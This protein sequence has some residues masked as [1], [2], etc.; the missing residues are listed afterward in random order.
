MT[1]DFRNILLVNLHFAVDI[2]VF[3]FPVLALAGVINELLRFYSLCFYFFVKFKGAA[4]IKK[5]F[6]NT[7]DG[8]SQLGKFIGSNIQAFAKSTGNYKIV[9]IFSKEFSYFISNSTRRTGNQ[10][11]LSI[12]FHK[13][14][15][16]KRATISVPE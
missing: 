16:T 6:L 3:E 4:A 8:N 1:Y 10:C 12:S 7:G 2:C 15:F 11:I 14:R 5:V 9:T 13:I